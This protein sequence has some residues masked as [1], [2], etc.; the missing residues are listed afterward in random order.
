MTIMTMEILQLDSLQPTP[1]LLELADKSRIKL[2]DVLDDVIVTLD[3]W[4]YPMYFFVIQPNTT[5]DG[6]PLILE[7]PWLAT[8]DALIGCRSREMTIANGESM[9]KLIMYPPLKIVLENSI[10]VED[11]Y[12]DEEIAQPL[13]TIEQSK[14]LKEQIEYNFLN[15]FI[16]TT[17]DAQYHQSS[18]PYDLI[19]SNDLQDNCDLASS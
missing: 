10:W 1:T 9:K 4:E 17:N 3:S 8:I 2:V 18:T 7:R 11:P 14:G 16:S 19:F 5:M 12:E 13:L 6:H 15:Q